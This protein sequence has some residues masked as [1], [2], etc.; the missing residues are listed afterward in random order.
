M[1]AK[2][3]FLNINVLMFTVGEISFLIFLLQNVAEISVKLKIY[4]IIEGRKS[5]TFSVLVT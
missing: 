4:H 2:I 5:L 1:N 3:S